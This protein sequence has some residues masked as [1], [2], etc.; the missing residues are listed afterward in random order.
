MFILQED[1][2]VIN[3]SAMEGKFYRFKTVNHPHTNM[4]CIFLYMFFCLAA[5]CFFCFV[6]ILFYCWYFKFLIV[7]LGQSQSKYD[8]QNSS[9]T[10]PL[11]YSPTLPSPPSL[12]DPRLS[13][14]LP[15]NPHF[16]PHTSSLPFLQ[17][18]LTLN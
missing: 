12:S 6:F 9:C 17:Y 3:V 11:T 5:F 2:Y 13:P 15:S 16:S 18:F 1:K 4:V 14:R 8:D 10:Y 7:F